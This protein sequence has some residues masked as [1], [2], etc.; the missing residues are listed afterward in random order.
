MRFISSALGNDS[1]I[2]FVGVRAK[3]IVLLFNYPLLAHMSHLW[4][5][6]ARLKEKGL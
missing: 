4:K 6:S 2:N 1:V 5:I 3:P